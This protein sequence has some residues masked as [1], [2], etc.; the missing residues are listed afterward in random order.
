MVVGLCVILS[1]SGPGP[2]PTP[3]ENRK[4]LER[5]YDTARSPSNQATQP[6]ATFNGKRLSSEE[7]TEL[8]RRLIPLL[9]EGA[10][11]QRRK[12]VE[13]FYTLAEQGRT[14]KTMEEALA[15]A[16]DNDYNHEIREVAQEA[17]S[18]L[19]ASKTQRR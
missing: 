11:E 4:Q 10:Y 18:Q 7:T 2:E 16:R 1:A 14:D 8:I 3:E 17:W 6:G 19:D 13:V 5:A 9:K 15:Y 12:A